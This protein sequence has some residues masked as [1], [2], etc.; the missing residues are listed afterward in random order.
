MAFNAFKQEVERV[1]LDPQPAKSV[2]VDFHFNEHDEA[3]QARE[4]RCGLKIEQEVAVMLSCPVGKSDEQEEKFMG[5]KMKELLGVLSMLEHKSKPTNEAALIMR[6]KTIHNIS[7]WQRTISSAVMLSISE[8]FDEALLTSYKR[9]IDYDLLLGPDKTE[10]EQEKIDQLIR[11]PLALGGD[12]IISTAER[13]HTS[14]VGGLCMA[15]ELR[16]H[17]DAFSEFF[18][19]KE[20]PNSQIHAHL[21]DALNVIKRQCK[22]A[23]DAIIHTKHVFKKRSTPEQRLRS[24]C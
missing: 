24:E 2:Y 19:G 11:S 3:T 5:E 23:D 16:T 8:S 9:K 6:M 22:V 4:H 13:C 20:R 17:L 10:D 12:G 18:D 7:Y 14:F 21:N 15:A 1:G